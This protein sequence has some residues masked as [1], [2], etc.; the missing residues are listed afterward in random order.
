[1]TKLLLLVQLFGRII[2]LCESARILGIVP[3]P[4]YS[5]Q[6]VFRPIWRELATRG[7]QL[8]VLTTNPINDPTLTNL[9]E[10]DLSFTYHLWNKK[11]NITNLIDV[12]QR[13]LVKYIYKY[14]LMTDDILDQELQHPEVRRIIENEKEHFDLVMIEYPYLAL[15][16]FAIRFNCPFIG[17]TALDAPASV[18]DTVGNPTHPVL[19][20]EFPL[21]LGSFLSFKERLISVVFQS[22]VRFY[23]SSFAYPKYDL[24]VRTHFG[25]NYPPLIEVA[26]NVS[27]LFVNVDPIFHNIRPIVPAVI[28]IGGGTHLQPQK[29]LPKVNTDFI[30]YLLN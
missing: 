14:I 23:V 17:M 7:H 12:A 11:H 19:N 29:H 27:L 18:Y 28:Q 9:K 20:P 30:K 15:M 2:Y 4:S 8:T 21:P 5:H 10:I 3:T 24:K 22:Y 1:M 16:A 26:K 13:D 25:E 6:I